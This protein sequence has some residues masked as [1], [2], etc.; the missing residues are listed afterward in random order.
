MSRAALL[1]QLGERRAG[2]GG[3]RVSAARSSL[4][5][6]WRRANWL[7]IVLGE[8]RAPLALF[9]LP[10]EIRDELLDELAPGLPE[11]AQLI[12]HERGIAALRRAEPQLERAEH[13]LHALR[14]AF[15]LLDAVLQAIDF[16][17]QLAIGFLELRTIAEQRE[18]P[19]CLPRP[20]RLPREAGA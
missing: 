2:I 10:R 16:V 6:A 15:L 9:L 18:D 4:S 20:A 3:D 17:L 12:E 7:A 19:V 14:R 8:M 11:A 5:T 13:F 1:L